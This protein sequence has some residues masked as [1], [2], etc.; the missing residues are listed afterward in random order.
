M[1]DRPSLWLLAPSLISQIVA[2]ATHV[3]DEIGI[4]A[5][6]A[7]LVDLLVGGGARVDSTGGRVHLQQSMIETA[8][9]QVPSEFSLYDVGGKRTHDFGSGRVHFT[10]G[11]AAI[12]ILDS[13]G[14]TQRKPNTADYVR[15][16]KV[17]SG[18]DRVDAQSTAF[19]PADVPDAVSDSYRLF[20]ALLYCEKPVVTGAFSAEAFELMHRFQVA[21]RG[22]EEELQAR[23]LTIFT[24]CPTTPLRWTDVGARNLHDCA[25]ARNP[26]EIVPVPMSGFVAPVTLVGTLVQHTAEVLSGV[27]IAQLANPGTPL[28]FGGCPAIFDIRYETA[29]MGAIETMMLTCALSEIGHFLGMPTQGYVAL[30]DSKALD[31]QAGLETGMGATLAALSGLD[32][33]SG[34]GILDFINCFSVEKLV[35]DHEICSMTDRLLAGVQPRDDFPTIPIIQELLAEKH[36][37]IADH[38]RAHLREEI[39]FSGAVIDRMGHA[40]W[41]EEG[42][43]TLIDRAQREISRLES[44]FTPSLLADET[45]D[46]LVSLM[47]AACKAHGMD[48]LPERAP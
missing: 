40:R 26:V 34:P 17:V 15:Y 29:P 10:P 41:D 30:S 42:N 43:P 14:Q 16:L 21:V 27:V 35:I 33:I 9:E 37:L 20:L 18:L 8:L 25:R 24:C 46:E 39:R 2:E 22:G 48:A 47:T 32:S 1:A 7:D 19:I 31:A 3:L 23:P 6:D 11:S 13:D 4:E 5:Q 45:K 44:D 12:N 36:L 38:T 28:L